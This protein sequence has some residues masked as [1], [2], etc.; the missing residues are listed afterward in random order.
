MGLSV[1]FSLDAI[2]FS[3][4]SYELSNSSFP[5]FS[6][7]MLISVLWSYVNYPTVSKFNPPLDEGRPILMAEPIM[8]D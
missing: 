6:L 7:S 3:Y 5:F 1:M 2:S 8:M 4:S